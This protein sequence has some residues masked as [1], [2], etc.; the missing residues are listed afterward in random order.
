L[1]EP[2]L[3]ND[4]NHERDWGASVGPD[5]GSGSGASGAGLVAS[6]SEAGKTSVALEGDDDSSCTWSGGDSSKIKGSQN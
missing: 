4:A 5:I 2:R 6:P 1:D 3:D